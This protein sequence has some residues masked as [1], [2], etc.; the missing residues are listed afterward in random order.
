MGRRRACGAWSR[1]GL[2]TGKQLKLARAVREAKRREAEM[3]AACGLGSKVTAIIRFLPAIS[4]TKIGAQGVTHIELLY[5]GQTPM[6][7]CRTVVGGRNH[8]E[9]EREDVHEP[10]TCP[11]CMQFMRMKM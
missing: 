11:W 8:L 1:S 3:S 4:P 6:A 5:E 10:P 9:S 2:M 7:A